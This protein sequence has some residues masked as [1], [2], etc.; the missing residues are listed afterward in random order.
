MPRRRRFLLCFEAHARDGW[1]WS[2]RTGHRW[3]LHKQV[4]LRV[5]TRTV[6]R[7]LTAQQPRAYLSGA[8]S[9]LSGTDAHLVIQ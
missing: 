9:T 3:T 4:E 8:Y 7:G 5:P 1:V 2:V 6:Y